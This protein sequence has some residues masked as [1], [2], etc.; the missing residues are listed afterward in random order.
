M[1][2]EAGAAVGRGLVAEDLPLALPSVLQ[3]LEAHGRDGTDG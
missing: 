1:H 2:A 3:R